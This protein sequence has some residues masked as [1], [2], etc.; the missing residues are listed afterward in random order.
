MARFMAATA[1][2][3]GLTPPLSHKVHPCGSL[4]AAWLVEVG[5]LTDMVHLQLPLGCT[6]RTGLGEEPVDQLVAP[7]AGHAR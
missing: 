1:D 6:D 2:H 7:G 3:E 4:T 5:E